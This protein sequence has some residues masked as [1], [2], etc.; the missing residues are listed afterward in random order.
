[1]PRQPSSIQQTDP[2]PRTEP[3]WRWWLKLGGMLSACSVFALAQAQAQT[4]A[5]APPSED[6][7]EDSESFFDE[8]SIFAT[9]NEIPAFDY[10][11][12]VT[13]IER[14]RVL[15]FNPSALAEIFQAIPGVQFDSGPR[16]TG[17]APTVRG[18]TGDGVLIFLDGARQSFV[19]GHDG[20]FFVDPELVK[21]VEVVRGPTSALYGSGALGGVIATRTITADDFLE[22]GERFG[23]RLS[24][25]FQS[26]N[27]EFRFGATGVYQSDDGL[28][29]LVGHLTYRDSG[30]IELG[31]G[32]TLPADDE[33][34][35]SLAKITLRP[36]QGLELFASYIRYG[37]DS[38]DP[39]NPQGVNIAGPGNEL[40]FRD[41]TNNTV[42]GGVRYAPA[43]SNL[44]DLNVVGYFSEN[45]VEEDEVENP[46]LTDRTVQTFGVSVDNRSRFMLTPDIDITLTYGGDYYLDQQTGT[47]TETVDGSR[48][49]VPDAE[50]EFFG[51][52]IQAEIDFASLGPIPGT[53]SIIPGVRFD[54]F[55]TDQ[56]GGT[57]M[58]DENEVSP[59]VGVAYKPVP[60]LLLFGNY[61]QGFRAPSFNEAFADG[62]HFAIPDLTAPPG[63]FGPRFVSNLFIENPDL[64]AETSDTYEVGIGVNFDSVVGEGDRLTAKASYYNSDVDNLIGLDVSTPAGCFSPFAAQ[65][66]PCGT[67]PAFGNFSQNINI[68]NA[69]IEGFEVEFSYNAPWMYLRGNFTAIDGVDEDTGE[70]LEGVLTPNTL[71]LDGGLKWQ[72][73]GLRVGAR[74][75][76]ADDFTEVNDPLEVRDS[77]VFS[78]VYAV[79]QPPEGILNGLRLDLGVDNI[80][81]ADFEIVNAG[82]SQPGRN[83]KLGVAWTQAF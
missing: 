19:S 15:D 36:T 54:S 7:L 76:V 61:A 8:M 65:F 10:P 51:A 11:G 79:W 46:R 37:S 35:S 30:D 52:F 13:V 42:Q 38:T 27:E 4:T 57:F 33:I 62:Q 23:Y 50:T 58:I 80:T 43:N 48:G 78:D 32:D 56:P 69:T 82:V 75:T 18:L 9:R 12:Q 47:D 49:G 59:K 17:D 77:F 26:V 1:M 83:F 73:Q 60:Q 41:V 22:R 81:D 31:S 72:S 5:L 40:V 71:F 21:A 39:Q 68:A 53:F 55:E 44:I 66:A 3:N 28:I 24:S 25:G 70:F 63:P 74:V 6:V 20:R 45:E 2:A 29:D 14:E 34:L 16:R 67:G 64:E